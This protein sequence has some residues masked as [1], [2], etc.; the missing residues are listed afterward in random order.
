[1]AVSSFLR[2]SESCDGERPRPQPWRNLGVTQPILRS[3]GEDL[4]NRVRAGR[5]A[6]LAGLLVQEPRLDRLPLIPAVSE[7]IGGLGRCMTNCP[8]AWIKP[9]QRRR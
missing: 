1:M 9:F 8:I 5:D 2:T 6:H 4:V 3:A 7:R